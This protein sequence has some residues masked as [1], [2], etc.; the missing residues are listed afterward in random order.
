M[1]SLITMKSNRTIINTKGGDIMSTAIT[2]RLNNEL[3]LKLRHLVAYYSNPIVSSTNSDVMRYALEKLYDNCSEDEQF[4]KRFNIPVKAMEAHCPACLNPE[5]SFKVE[6]FVKAV[7]QM[8]QGNGENIKY[9][10]EDCGEAWTHD[11][12]IN[13]D[14]DDLMRKYVE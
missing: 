10:C 5:A 11:E 8:K 13:G 4:R 3:D 1:I 9:K 14:I 12:L 7:E 2:V 6:N